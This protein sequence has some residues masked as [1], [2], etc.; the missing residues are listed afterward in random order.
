M[1][2]I[3]GLFIAAAL[4]VM[5]YAGAQGLLFHSAHAAE[6]PA[7]GDY[8]G[9]HLRWAW[10]GCLFICLTHSLALVYFLGT[11]K[12]I[13]EQ[14][15]LGKLDEDFYKRSRKLMS[16]AIV[17]AV[18]AI[19]AIFG[20][21]LSGGFTLIQWLSPVSHLIA[22]ATALAIQGAVFIR[23]FQIIHRNGKLMDEVMEKLGAESLGVAL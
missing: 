3:Y 1:K 5:C 18:A 21:F 10:F 19:L 2:P 17:P 12:L 23:Q 20:A 16:Q 4:G 9:A 22:A 15:D 7:A 14:V 11:G 13:R 8:F 6:A